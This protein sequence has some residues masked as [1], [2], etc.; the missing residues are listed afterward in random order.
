MKIEIRGMIFS[1][2]LLSDEEF[3]SI[4]PDADAI[5]TGDHRILF[6]ESKITLEL[7]R[8]ELVHAY[9]NAGITE[10]MDLSPIQVE[11][12]IASIMQYFGDDYFKKCN[13]IYRALKQMEKKRNGKKRK[14]RNR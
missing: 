13:I 12:S 4:Y 9:F 5:C 14:T 8:H 7:I 3:T 10:S 11:E 1:I 2:Y 6:R